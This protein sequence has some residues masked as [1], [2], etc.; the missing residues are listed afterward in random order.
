MSSSETC[1][2]WSESGFVAIDTWW[3]CKIQQLAKNVLVPA[4]DAIWI[5]VPPIY[6]L[7]IFDQSYVPKM[8]IRS[9]ESNCKCCGGRA[10]FVRTTVLFAWSIKPTCD[11]TVTKSSKSK[12][13]SKT[14]SAY[15]QI[16][17][18]RRHNADPAT[19]FG[20]PPSQI[21]WN[22]RRASNFHSPLQSIFG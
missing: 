15:V 10:S 6:N 18:C 7:T 22:E 2:C 20:H 19:L 16:I 14:I 9:P 5:L 13:I 11:S 8:A 3:F 21:L 4:D 1:P 12:T 17:G